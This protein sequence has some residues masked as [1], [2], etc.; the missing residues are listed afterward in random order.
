[1][2]KV[3]LIFII[4]AISIQPHASADET[5]KIKLTYENEILKILHNEIFVPSNGRSTDSNQEISSWDKINDF[6]NLSTID[7]YFF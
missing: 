4:M 7:E 6:L 2:Q 5:L 1:M 3:A